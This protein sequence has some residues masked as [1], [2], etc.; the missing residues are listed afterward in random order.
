MAESDDGSNT[1]LNAR[2]VWDVKEAALMSKYRHQA[3]NFIG[4]S[5]L[6]E[7]RIGLSWL[8][9]DGADN[10]LGAVARDFAMFDATVSRPLPCTV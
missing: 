6:R 9:P 4:F 8:A 5:I 1:R 7:I 10:I 2:F 3:H